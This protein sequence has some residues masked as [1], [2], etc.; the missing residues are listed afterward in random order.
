MFVCELGWTGDGT[1]APAD[2]DF[3]SFVPVLAVVSGSWSFGGGGAGLPYHCRVAA[4][5]RPVVIFSSNLPRWKPGFF[6]P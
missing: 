2:G 3:L 1:Y 4:F 6:V 5:L